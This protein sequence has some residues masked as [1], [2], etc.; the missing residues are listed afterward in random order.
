[1]LYFLDVLH[2]YSG[3]VT[4]NEGW[5][6]VWSTMRWNLAGFARL[7]CCCGDMNRRVEAFGSGFAIDGKE[8][9]W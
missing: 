7:G 3:V 5:R 8:G 2:T 4:G 9:Q 1:M 6:V